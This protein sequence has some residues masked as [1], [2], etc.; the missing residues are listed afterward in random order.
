MYGS[1]IVTTKHPWTT[2]F[3]LALHCKNIRYHT[4]IKVC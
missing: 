3:S 4:Y 1:Y 2:P